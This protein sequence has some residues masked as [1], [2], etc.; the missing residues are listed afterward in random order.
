MVVLLLAWRFF[1]GPFNVQDIRL[2][3]GAGSQRLPT[4]RDQVRDWLSERRAAIQG[5]D[6]YPVFVVNT[7]GGGARSAYW[8]ASLLSALQDHDPTFADH[9]FAISSVSGG[10]LG[11]AVFA[12]M[13][14]EHQTKKQTPCAAFLA[15]ISP[16]QPRTWQECAFTV[17]HRD[18]LSSALAAMLVP[19]L[20]RNV[21]PVS[22]TADRATALEQGFEA[23]WYGPNDTKAFSS[24]PEQLWRGDAAL[25]VPSLFLNCTDATTGKRLVFSNVRLGSDDIARGDLRAL[26]GDRSI[27]LS[28]AVLLSGRFPGISPA[29]WL[30]A[31]TGTRDQGALVVDGGYVDNSGTLTA[32]EVV[33][34]LRDA[35]KSKRRRG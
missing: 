20:V 30:P 13:V 14:E 17:L 21:W 8:T 7:D 22:E 19:D 3:D 2:L 4:L 29:G 33:D 31:R 15:F 16:H 25:H 10:S 18:F 27:R 32:N 34:A 6:Q 11:A 12:A 35:I 23:A 5:V 28:T 24:R 26:L 1:T 9:L